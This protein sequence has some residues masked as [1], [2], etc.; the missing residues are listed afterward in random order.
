M[1]CISFIDL[2]IL[3][4]FTL[5]SHSVV[6]LPPGLWD[7]YIFICLFVFLLTLPHG[8]SC[9]RCVVMCFTAKSSL[10][11]F[12]RRSDG[13]L[14]HSITWQ[15]CYRRVLPLLPRARLYLILWLEELLYHTDGVN[16]DSLGL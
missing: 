13:S 9:L 6:L 7:A 10:A 5:Q 12:C 15:H 16:S 4:K 11:G 1:T 8:E 3:N 2:I 14:F